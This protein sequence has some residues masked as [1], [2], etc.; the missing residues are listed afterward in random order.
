MIVN[1][2]GFALHLRY[3]RKR[4]EDQVGRRCECSQQTGRLGGYG[5]RS[6]RWIFRVPMPTVPHEAAEPNDIRAVGRREGGVEVASR[7]FGR[8][9]K[10]AGYTMATAVTSNSNSGIKRSGGPGR[11][12]RCIE[13]PV[14]EG[15]L[16]P[17][18]FRR[19]SP[20]LR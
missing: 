13:T 18:Y 2:Y 10:V 11:R 5:R 16:L 17:K 6:E 8:E 7:D 9:G 3:I 4:G 19:T 14:A 15:K 1:L 20:T 12:M